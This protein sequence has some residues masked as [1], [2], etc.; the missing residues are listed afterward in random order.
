[1]TLPTINMIS[2][3]VYHYDFLRKWKRRPEEEIH[4]RKRNM[5]H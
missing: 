4:E 5:G 1:M 3:H 2:V